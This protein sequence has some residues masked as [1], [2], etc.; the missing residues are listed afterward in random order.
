MILFFGMDLRGDEDLLRCML[1]LQV[2]VPLQAEAEVH[3]LHLR[4]PRKGRRA[5]AGVRRRLDEDVVELE[6]LVDDVECVEVAKC[7]GKG[8]D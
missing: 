1:L 8:C 3:Q 6:V 7:P 4:R 5:G 2:F